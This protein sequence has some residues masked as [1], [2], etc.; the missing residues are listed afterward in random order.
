MVI[1]DCL[2]LAS[3]GHFLC[4]FTTFSDTMGLTLTAGHRQEDSVG[5]QNYQD[6]NISESPRFNYNDE[7]LL[8]LIMMTYIMND[9]NDTDTVTDTDNELLSISL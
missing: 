5:R 7:D 6:E 3:L 8:L 9:D 4:N 2:T 1:L